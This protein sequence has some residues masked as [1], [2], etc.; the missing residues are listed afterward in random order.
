VAWEAARA[1]VASTV[2]DRGFWV[3]CLSGIIFLSL[4]AY[5]D[6][7]HYGIAHICLQSVVLLGLAFLA[8]RWRRLG[9]WWRIALAI[10]W[11]ADLAL[12]I[13]LQFGVEDFAFDRWLT[14][15]RSLAD[16][17]QTYTGVSQLNLSEKIIAHQAYFSDILP[18]RPMFILALLG[19]LLCLA[20]LR[21]GRIQGVPDTP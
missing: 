12:G 10:G 5:G 4:A 19:A 21:A 16:V 18:T 11:T 6:R 13:A 8:S 14:P 1:A 9:G 3:I 15:D 20:L 17:S 7:D 2:R